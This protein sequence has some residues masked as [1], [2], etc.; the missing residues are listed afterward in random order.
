MEATH[1][2]VILGLDPRM[3]KAKRARPVVNVGESHQRLLIAA[4]IRLD[5]WQVD[6]AA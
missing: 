3:T 5:S 1:T 4:L 6:L 2:V